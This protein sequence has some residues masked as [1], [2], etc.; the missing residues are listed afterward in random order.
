M[1]SNQSK[2]PVTTPVPLETNTPHPPDHSQAS[3][4]TSKPLVEMVP[5]V[6][7]PKSAEEV[8]NT[9]PPVA[10]VASNGMQ[11]RESPHQE[12]ESVKTEGII[13]TQTDPTP[14]TE[15]QQQPVPTTELREPLLPE[16]TQPIQSKDE[17]SPISD[18]PKLPELSENTKPV[19]PEEEPQLVP[20]DD[21]KQLTEPT[22]IEQV[23]LITDNETS[24]TETKD[25]DIITSANTYTTQS[26]PSVV[27][28]ASN[29]KESVL[30]TNHSTPDRTELQ[31]V[32]STPDTLPTNT[33]SFPISIPLM[34][35]QDEIVIQSE[36][37]KPPEIHLAK[38]E[39]QLPSSDV[40]IQTEEMVT[41]PS[42][43]PTAPAVPESAVL[44]EMEVTG[45]T[46]PDITSSSADSL[47][48]ADCSTQSS[49]LMQT[50]GEE[51]A[52][53]AKPID[54]QQ[55]E[56]VVM[57]VAT[58]PP[59]Q[60]TTP[61][62]PDA[63]KPE[64]D[65]SSPKTE[66]A[67]EVSEEPMSPMCDTEVMQVDPITVPLPMEEIQTEPTPQ[68]QT[69]PI[70][71]III[72]DSPAP[73]PQEDTMDV[74]DLTSETTPPCKR[75]KVSLPAPS[76]SCPSSSPP[77]SKM[78]YDIQLLEQL[79]NSC[80]LLSSFSVQDQ[81]IR[82]SFLHKTVCIDCTLICLEDDYPQVTLT[83]TSKQGEVCLS[84]TVL[85]IVLDILSTF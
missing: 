26:I 14:T 47:S 9:P 4:V 61:T 59:Q 55:E 64:K 46:Q 41:E 62:P 27:E 34:A 83:L 12:T 53:E 11:E 66:P 24:V 67:V 75:S 60:F 45:E 58:E 68:L 40:T 39:Q 30:Q 85:N 35:T 8:T 65:L 79:V 82:F 5:D 17:P 22:P 57:D 56:T 6:G 74:I 69:L 52:V 54:K 19:S 81:R 48:R 18:T 7:Q 32:L 44:Q 77:V 38:K 51:S 10:K 72:L 1:A 21:P 23:P 36:P 49:E 25:Q 2:I 29:T 42:P 37:D 43:A 50:D 76:D 78:V 71:T 70:D 16:T 33:E 80:E 13:Q 84:K 63:C 31:G 28:E 73:A 15:T 20:K 3:A